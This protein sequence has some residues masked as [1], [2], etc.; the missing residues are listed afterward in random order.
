MRS[1][2]EATGSERSRNTWAATSVRSDWLLAVR[3]LS[4]VGGVWYE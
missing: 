3:A 1:Q 2:P 4:L